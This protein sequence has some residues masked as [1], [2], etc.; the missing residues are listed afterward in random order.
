MK[1]IRLEELSFDK[2]EG[3]KENITSSSWSK[4]ARVRRK[5]ELV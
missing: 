1:L 2:E 5:E 3:Q 4:F